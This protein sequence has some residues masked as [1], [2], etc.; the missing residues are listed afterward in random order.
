MPQSE[1]IS[2]GLRVLQE[3]EKKNIKLDELSSNQKA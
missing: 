1:E 2:E 3:A